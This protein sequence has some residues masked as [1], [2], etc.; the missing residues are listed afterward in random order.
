LLSHQNVSD[1]PQ[2][3]LKE[4][5]KDINISKF[6]NYKFI[7]FMIK[8][9]YKVLIFF[10]SILD[11]T[12]YL[13]KTNLPI[14]KIKFEEKFGGFIDS[15]KAASLKE[16]EKQF[17]QFS[18]IVILTILAIIPMFNKVHSSPNFFIALICLILMS[19]KASIKSWDE[20]KE[21]LVKYKARYLL[22]VVL[23]LGLFFIV[24]HFRNVIHIEN[25]FT[26]YELS[27]THFIWLEG[28]SGGIAL[29]IHS[30]YFI[31]IAFLWVVNLIKKIIILLGIGMLSLSKKIAPNHSFSTLLAISGILIEFIIWLI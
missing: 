22:P 12:P 17:D 6:C 19:F 30:F 20:V 15:A 11:K 23:Y 14:W 31:S 16:N 4:F 21:F 1:I 18:E 29:L 8:L 25:Y 9:L 7:S 2:I 5:F 27:K 28:I 13:K 3:S 24:V 10:Y 26:K